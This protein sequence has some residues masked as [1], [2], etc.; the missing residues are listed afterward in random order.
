MNILAEGLKGR[1][2]GF[3]PY[4]GK[5]KSMTF[6]YIKEK[7]WKRIQG[8]KEKLLLKAGKEILIK[9]ATQAIL[10]YVMACFDLTKSL[11]SFHDMQILV[12][13]NG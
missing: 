9:A 4:I 5:G 13:P 12:E 8:W 1:Y 6:H 7:V 2:L 11:P 10:V 3:P